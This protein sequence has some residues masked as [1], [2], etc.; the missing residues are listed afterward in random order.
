MKPIPTITLKNGDRV[1]A[2]GQGTWNM[3]ESAARAADEVRALQHG[4]ALGMTLIDTAEMYG[5]GGAE[6]VVGKAIAGRRDA[7]YLVSKVLPFNASRAGTVKACEASL[8]RLQVERIDL[9]LLH[10]RG[11]HPFAATIEAMETLIDHGKIGAWGVSNLDLDDMQELLEQ[12]NGH[13]VQV[14][15]VLY[16]LSRRGVEFDLL[17]FGAEQNIA[18]MAYSPIEQGR[19]LKDAALAAVAK[20]H[21]VTPAQVALA[22]TL[23]RPGVIS[24]PKASTVQH[25]QDNRTCLDLILDATD[26]AELDRAFAPPKKRRPLEML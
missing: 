1:P 14:N 7:V 11:A 5:D 12:D 17:P 3:G 13:H 20:R 6:K 16:N 9:Y 15:Q 26:L 23:R 10:W 21:G 22:W 4:I 19:I 25:V 2:L 8:K 24:I 18:L